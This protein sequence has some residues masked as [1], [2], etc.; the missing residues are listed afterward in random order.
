MVTRSHMIKQ[1]LTLIK[2]RKKIILNLLHING[3]VG[4][5]VGS[6]GGDVVFVGKQTFVHHSQAMGCTNLY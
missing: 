3:G 4:G 1:F 5:G 6:G 2:L